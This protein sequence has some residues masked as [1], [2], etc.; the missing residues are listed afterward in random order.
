M[1]LDNVIKGFRSMISDDKTLWLSFFN[2]QVVLFSIQLEMVNK[3]V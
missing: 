3:N 2:L 1:V